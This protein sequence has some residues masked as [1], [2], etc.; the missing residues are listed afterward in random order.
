MYSITIKRQSNGHI[1]GVVTYVLEG[2]YRAALDQIV[3]DLDFRR[4]STSKTEERYRNGDVLVI[5]HAYTDTPTQRIISVA[6][7]AVAGV[8]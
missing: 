8:I 7:R 4:V 3:K 2:H 6:S 1:F 5:G